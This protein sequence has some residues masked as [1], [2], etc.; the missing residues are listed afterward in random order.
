M[1]AFWDG[2]WAIEVFKHCECAAGR[3]VNAVLEGYR[4]T[5]QNQVRHACT[6]VEVR[7]QANADRLSL[8]Y[9]R[10]AVAHRGALG[11][12]FWESLQHLQDDTSKAAKLY[13][14]N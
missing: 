5:G 10:Y 12:I 7:P 2:F 11:Q 6:E 3:R 9:L 4:K 1:G 8:Q 14:D 13:G